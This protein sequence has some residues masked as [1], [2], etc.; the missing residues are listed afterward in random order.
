ME[1]I[2]AD[3]DAVCYNQDALGAIY[4]SMVPWFYGNNYYGSMFL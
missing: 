4:D 3:R 2:G 1:Q